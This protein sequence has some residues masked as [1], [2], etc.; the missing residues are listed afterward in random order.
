MNARARLI[1]GST[2]RDHS[3]RGCFEHFAHE[4]RGAAQTR[5]RVFSPSSVF[6]ERHRIERF[7]AQELSSPSSFSTSGTVS[8][9]PMQKPLSATSGTHEGTQE[10]SGRVLQPPFPRPREADRF[11]TSGTASSDSM[12]EPL[13]QRSEPTRVLKRPPAE[14]ANPHSR[15]HGRRIDSTVQYNAV[16]YKAGLCS[17]VQYSI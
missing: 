11:S 12:Q 7:D 3:A 5:T 15:S 9:D 10:A 8:S 17:K 1:R 6:D 14:S 16:Q 4:F 13:Q 2:G